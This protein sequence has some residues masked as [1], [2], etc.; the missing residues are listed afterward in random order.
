MDLYEIRRKV[1]Y[2]P[3]AP[4]TQKAVVRNWL[5]SLHSEFQFGLTLTLKQSM[6]IEN[7][8]GAHFSKLKRTDCD[9]ITHRFIQKLN[10]QVFGKAAERYGK[11]LRYIPIVEGER[12]GKQLH[13]HMKRFVFIFPNMSINVSR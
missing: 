3:T 2:D 10:R 6:L 9:A 4:L 13:F 1:A 7:G 5:I 11:T 12:S 8:R